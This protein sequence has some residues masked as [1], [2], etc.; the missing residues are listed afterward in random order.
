VHHQGIHQALDNRALVLAEALGLPAT[1]GVRQVNLGRLL[2]DGDVVGKGDVLA[3]NII[4]GPDVS[5]HAH[6]K[7]D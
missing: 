5:I 1:S 7:E 2:L 3:G 6:E 4:V